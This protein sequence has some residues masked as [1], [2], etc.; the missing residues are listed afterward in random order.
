MKP[1]WFLLIV[2]LSGF[3]LDSQ[4]RELDSIARST[5]IMP[6]DTNKV[7]AYSEL[8]WSQL[9]EGYYNEAI[10]TGETGAALAWKINDYHGAGSCLGMV[11]MAQYR[12]YDNKSAIVSSEK[13]MAAYEQGKSRKGICWAHDQISQC[14]YQMG[15]NAK[16]LAHALTALQ[17]RKED[18]DTAALAISYNTIGNIYQETG[19]Y[20]NAIHFISEGLDLYTTLGDT[21]GIAACNLNLGIVYFKQNLDSIAIEF[22]YKALT[23]YRLIAL[24]GKSASVLVNIGNVYYRRLNY[25]SALTYFRNAKEI[26]AAVGNEARTGF[27]YGNIGNIYQD[28]QQYD[29]ALW[30]M[31]KAYSIFSA[32]EDI[33][34]SGEQLIDIA[35]VLYAQGKYD[36]ARKSAEDGLKLATEARSREEMADAYQLLAKLYA[37]RNDFSRAYDYQLKYTVM[38]DSLFNESSVQVLNEMRARYETE[39]KDNEIRMLNDSTALQKAVNDN[40]VIAAGRAEVVRNSFIAGF[41]LVGGIAFFIFRGYR[42]KKKANELITAQKS[43]VEHQ[44]QIIEEK[45]KDILDSITYA[46]RLQEAI[47]PPVE[48][49]SSRLPGSYLLYLPKDI[50]A[51][52]FYFMEAIGTK[53]IIAAADCTGHGVPGAMVSVVCSNALSRAVKEFRLTDPGKILDKVRELVMETFAKSTNDVQDGMDISLAVIDTS[54]REVQW[55][56]AH[57]PLWYFSGGA[58][59]EL[60]ADK[61]PVGRA[62][63]A[64]EFTTHRIQLQKG[65]RIYLFTDGFADQFGGPNGKKFKYKPL[66]ELLASN[67]DDPAEVQREKLQRTF[68]EWKGALE[69]VDDVCILSIAV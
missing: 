24:Y 63:H 25:D 34:Y 64:K 22:Y 3:K 66:K 47:L 55:A 59:Q 52:D 49:I 10:K 1:T 6:D 7:Y 57:N 4:T 50:V 38:H 41:I 11:S 37:Q 48:Q 16:A 40:L 60:T 21:S 15:N 62:D 29:S 20:V 42:Q 28:Q 13:A 18:N 67:A 45:N 32:A 43:E 46:K 23:Q 51:G 53:T 65:D 68:A 31:R 19:D 69:Q 14:Y 56:G 12:K 61:Q 27:C 26:Y 5:E 17:I 2:L 58:M 39:K 9:S 33:K 44:K 30:Y 54:R 8:A 35:S 36:E